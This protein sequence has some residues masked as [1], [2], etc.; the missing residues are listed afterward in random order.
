[1]ANTGSI[2]L[3]GETSSQE[4]V[5]EEN[6]STDEFQNDDAQD[7]SFW[8]WEVV[9]DEKEIECQP[10]SVVVV[11]PDIEVYQKEEDETDFDPLGVSSDNEEE[12][13]IGDRDGIPGKRKLEEFSKKVNT[14]LK[15]TYASTSES[16][17]LEKKSIISSDN[18]SIIKSSK[19]L[20][21]CLVCNKTF[22]LSVALRNH[23]RVHTGEKP[24][25]C[26]LCGKSFSGLP[27][28]SKHRKIHTNEKPFECAECGKKFKSNSKLKAHTRI[29]TG[30]RPYGC[31]FC[32]KA[33]TSWSNLHYHKQGHTDIKPFIC[34]IC[35]KG[36]S[37]KFKLNA[38]Q[39]YHTGKKSLQVINH[40]E[41]QPA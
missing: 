35:G 39:R 15:M 3:S 37:V 26:E 7:T 13:E 21:C 16:D 41:T 6:E 38:H 17:I 4:V 40:S 11:T 29:H 30:E 19:K 24:Y 14:S 22:R 31:D 12:G 27:N 23:T 2:I 20:H 33:F 34:P 28:F 18:S 8:S 10:F 1:M 32:G 9:K 5:K 36:F 25:Q